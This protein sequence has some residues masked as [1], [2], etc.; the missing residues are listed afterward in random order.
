MA[1]SDLLEDADGA[2]YPEDVQRIW[3]VLG[4]SSIDPLLDILIE[5]GVCHPD[6]ARSDIGKMLDYLR[7]EALVALTE[8]QHVMVPPSGKDLRWTCAHPLCGWASDVFTTPEM[9][10]ARWYQTHHEVP[11]LAVSPDN[12]LPH[13]RACGIT[14]H[15]HGT[16]CASDCPTC[17]DEARRARG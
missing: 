15:P 10:G 12:G 14:A 11:I 17:G 2:P 4:D 1:R 6:L 8:P 5:R 7:G 9:R 3:R 16:T 13:S